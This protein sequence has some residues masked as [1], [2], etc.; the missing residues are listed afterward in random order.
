MKNRWMD[1]QILLQI[2]GNLI[3]LLLLKDLVEEIGLNLN[4]EREGDIVLF[5]LP[6]LHLL[7]PLLKEAVSQSSQNIL[8]RREDANLLPLLNLLKAM[9][10]IKDLD[11]PFLRLLMFIQPHNLIGLQRNQKLTIQKFCTSTIKGLRI[12]FRT[13]ILLL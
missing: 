13:R 7:C 10:S 5:H 3:D 9:V 12:R 8:I 6:L 11:I 1:G 4:I 2:P